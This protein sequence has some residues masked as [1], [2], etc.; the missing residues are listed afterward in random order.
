MEVCCKG[1]AQWVSLKSLPLRRESEN[2][3][4]ECVCSPRLFHILCVTPSRHHLHCTSVG[5]GRKEESYRVFGGIGWLYTLLVCTYTVLV[6]VTP[7]IG[8]DHKINSMPLYHWSS[9]MHVHSTACCNFLTFSS[10]QH[11]DRLP[12]ALLVDS[13][14]AC[15]RL[16]SLELTWVTL[17]LQSLLAVVKG[18]HNL[19]ALGLKGVSLSDDRVSDCV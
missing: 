7:C 10:Y 11:S 14:V 2:C 12:L 8:G 9:L 15:Q 19:R 1:H 17:S 4:E 13:L 18:L 6:C 3:C 5:L 16:T